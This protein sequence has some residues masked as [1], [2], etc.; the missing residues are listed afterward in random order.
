[1]STQPAKILKIEAGN[2]KEGGAADIVIF[3]PDEEWTVD[4]SLFKSKA[5]NTPFGG[6]RLRGKVKYTI[7]QGKITYRE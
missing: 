7:S 1:M 5:R 3:D 6:M 4:P 2:L